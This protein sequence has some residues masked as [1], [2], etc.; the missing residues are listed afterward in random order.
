MKMEMPDACYTDSNIDGF[1]C[2]GSGAQWWSEQTGL[3][4]VIYYW[5]IETQ[6]LKIAASTQHE[7]NTYSRKGQ[8]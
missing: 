1:C 3:S 8:K 2:S 6:S 7:P 5:T 4:R